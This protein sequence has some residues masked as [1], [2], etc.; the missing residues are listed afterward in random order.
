MSV[1]EF[2]RQRAVD[3]NVSGSY[4]L[5]RWYD[6]EGKLRTFACRTTRVSPIRMIVD[7]PVVGRIGD[8]LTSYFRDFGKF[9]GHI[10][11]TMDGSV[12]RVLFDE[13]VPCAA[14]VAAS[15]PFRR[16]SAAFLAD[17][18]C[19]RTLRHMCYLAVGELANW[20]VGESVT[21]VAQLARLRIRQITN[22]PIHQLDIYPLY[23]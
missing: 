7:V 13:R 14:I 21:R 23:A 17:E 9:G 18:D 3:V 2:L 11:D 1:S 15:E 6:C 20:R 4:S 16:L 10:S 5:H 8:R 19:G 12:L 22:S